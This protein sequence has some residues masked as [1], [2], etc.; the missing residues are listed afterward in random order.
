MKVSVI[1]STYNN[2]AWLEKVLWGYE[3]QTYKNFELI[4]ADDGSRSPTRELISQFQHESWMDIVHVWHADDG[5]QKSAILNKAIQASSTDYLIFSDG[6]CIPRNDFVEVHVKNLKKG[7]F[8][9][10]GYFKLPMETSKVITREDIVK[11]NT[12]QID[13]LYAHGLKRTFKSIKLTSRGLK[14]KLLNSLTPTKATWNGHNSSGWKSDILVVN[15]FNEN[16]QYGGQDRELGERLVNKGLKG[17]QIRY[18]AICVHLDHARGYNTRESIAKNKNIRADTRQLRKVW[19]RFGIIK[20]QF[21]PVP[22]L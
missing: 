16:M 17:I 12:F 19:T 21:L 2:P 11:G 18:S 5:F 15:G 9:S 13:W 4:I 10:G 3:C 1:V 6:D 20:P 8:L 7:Y 14:E 22:Q